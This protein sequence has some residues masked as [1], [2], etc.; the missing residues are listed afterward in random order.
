[1]GAARCEVLVL[2]LIM[3]VAEFRSNGLEY[4]KVEYSVIKNSENQQKVFLHIQY[5]SQS[6][7]PPTGVFIECF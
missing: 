6:S 4:I 2:S 7:D 5:N 1:M 3:I